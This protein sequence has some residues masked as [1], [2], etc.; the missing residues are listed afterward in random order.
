MDPFKWIQ[1]GLDLIEGVGMKF[2][3][4]WEIGDELL[5]WVKETQHGHVEMV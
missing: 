5:K 3:A 1:K 4:D 2:L